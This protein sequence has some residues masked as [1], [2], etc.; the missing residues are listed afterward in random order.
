MEAFACARPVVGSRFPPTSD[1]VDEGRTGW[2]F[3]PG[4]PESLARVIEDA[5]ANPEE[6]ARRGR[7]ARNEYETHYTPEVNYRMLMEIYRHALRNV[8]RG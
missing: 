1:L 3:E 6:C 7:E 4:D 8:V 5:A 2:L